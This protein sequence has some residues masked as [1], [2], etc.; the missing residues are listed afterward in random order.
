[1]TVYVDDMHKFPM[2]NFRSMKMSHMVAD[3]VKELHEMADKIG[4]SRAHYQGP[5][6]TINPHYDICL[7]KRALAVKHGAKEC[8]MREGL[9]IMQA[10]RK[11]AI[12]EFRGLKTQSMTSNYSKEKEDIEF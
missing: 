12:E 1:M 11:E 9:K 3:T 8:T 4:V 10:M 7:S 6:K 2:G 5:P